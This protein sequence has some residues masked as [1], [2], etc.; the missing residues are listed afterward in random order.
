MKAILV[1]LMLVIPAFGV[2]LETSAQETVHLYEV[3]YPSLKA[4]LLVLY[5]FP[6]EVRE[7]GVPIPARVGSDETDIA[8]VSHL[9]KVVVPYTV[10]YELAQEVF[11]DSI[12]NRRRL[13]VREISVQLGLIHGKSATYE[14]VRSSTCPKEEAIGDTLRT[15]DQRGQPRCASYLPMPSFAGVATE[16][17]FDSIY[18]ARKVQIEAYADSVALADSLSTAEQAAQMDAVM[19]R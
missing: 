3:A 4:D 12:G 9:A 17:L 2:E 11:P 10:T 7:S 6:S 19:A 14:T 5:G 18:T 16:A 15:G 13:G 8:L 1:L